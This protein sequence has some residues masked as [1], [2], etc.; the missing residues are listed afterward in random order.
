MPKF[1]VLGDTHGKTEHVIKACRIAKR[2]ECD[3]IVQLGDWG[4]IWKHWNKKTGRLE[5]L[6]NALAQFDQKMYFLDGNHDDHDELA[7]LGAAHDAPGFVELHERVFYM[8]RGFAW[9]WDGVRFMSLG[10]A[11]SVD[12]DPDDEADW[13]GRVIGVVYWLNETISDEEVERAKSRGKIDVLLTHDAPSTQDLN[14]IMMSG[15]FLRRRMNSKTDRESLIN[16]LKINDVI[17][18]CQPALVM[19]GH[20]H[21]RY[22]GLWRYDTVVHGLDRDG[23]GKESWM[24][25][26]TATMLAEVE[27]NRKKLIS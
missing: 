11:F 10:G 6:A 23:Q 25:L 5:N 20:F 14:N 12:I 22:A 15:P 7:R 19:H 4:F 2:Y 13:P 26:D 9:D 8:P 18:V 27:D 17:E 21:Y 16:R 1:L 24:V 3:F